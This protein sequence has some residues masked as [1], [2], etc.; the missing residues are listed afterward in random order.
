MASSPPTITLRIPPGEDTGARQHADSRLKEGSEHPEDISP[1]QPRSRTAVFPRSASASHAGLDTPSGRTGPPRSIRRSLP[2]SP[3]IFGN[4]SA[5]EEPEEYPFDS[6]L[7]GSEFRSAL[8][9][10]TPDPADRKGKRRESSLWD[11]SWMNPMQWFAESPKDEKAN[12]SFQEDEERKDEDAGKPETAAASPLPPSATEDP[13]PSPS[14]PARNGLRRANSSLHPEHHSINPQ[15]KWGRLRSLLPT[16]AHQAAS[17]PRNT[18]TITSKS[19]N[20]VD[21]L[22]VGGLSPLLLRLWFE[23]DEKD[24]RRIPFLLHRLRIRITDSLYAMDGRKAVFRIEC[25]YANGGTFFSN[26]PLS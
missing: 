15:R 13:H 6:T 14:S 2:S 16:I 25:E 3:I 19:V 12:S 5:R 10:G 9:I 23:R 20:I 21:E 1:M 24:H 26:H 18:S 7:S 22:M 11:A 4:G 17:S 8:D